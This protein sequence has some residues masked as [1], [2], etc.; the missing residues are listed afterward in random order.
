MRP[1]WLYPPSSGRHDDMLTADGDLRAH[2]LEILDSLNGLEDIP[3]RQQKA[4]RILRDDGATYNIYG[5]LNQQSTTWNLDLV[6]NVIGS[7]EWAEVESG[8]LERA[9]LF[10]LVLRDIYGERSLVRNGVIPPE[11]LFCHRGFL[12]ACHGIQLPGE[13]DLILH[14]VDLIREPSGGF[15][16][17]GD[18]TQSPSGAGYALEN[19]TVMSRVFPSLF[20]DSHV[21]RL[22]AFFQRL[23]A[24]LLSL[25]PDPAQARVALLTPGPHNETYFEHAYMA[26]YMGFPLVQSDDLMVRNGRLW[27]KSLDGLKRVDVLLRRVDDWFCDPVELRSDSRLGV[28]GLLEVVRAGN[29]VVANPLGSGIIENPVFLKYLPQIA[30][31]LLGRE[32]RLPSVNTWWCG[33]AEDKQYV[34]ANL[35]D[36]VIKPVYRKPGN[37]S[38]RACELDQNGLQQ[39]AQRIEQDPLQY[40]AQPYLKAGHLPA[41]DGSQLAP[42]PSVLRSFAVASAESYTLMPGGLTR[43]GAEE[44][45][46]VIANQAGACSKDT[47]VV[48]SEP[49]RLLSS[50][51]AE[52]PVATREAESISLPSRVVENLFWMGRYAERAESTLRI[53]RTTFMQFSSES[54]ASPVVKTHLLQALQKMAILLPDNLPAD[55][56]LERWVRDGTLSNSI[57]SNLN[58]MLFCADQAKELLSSDTFRIINDI[59]DALVKLPNELNNSLGSA[60]EEVLDPLVT[61]LMAFAGLTQESMNRSFGWRFMELGRRLERAQQINTAIRGLL[62]PVVNE[63]EQNRLAESLLLTL[64]TLISYRRRYRGR[65]SV[66]TS[67]DLILLDK[68]NP[69]SLLYQLETIAEHL[70]ALPHPATV[71]HELSDEER[72]LMQAEVLIKLTPLKELSSEEETSPSGQQNAPQEQPRQTPANAALQRDKLLSAMTRCHQLMGALNDQITDKYFDHREASQ[73]LV[74]NSMEIL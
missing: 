50:E 26:N 21:H 41:L 10:N 13:H 71:L 55:Q 60:P 62:V 31:A 22:S 7:E 37:M 45:S 24:K 65:M 19:R 18:R 43:S 74:R 32:L 49:E 33:D 40:V 73:Q 8:L 44:N 27:M 39:L 42:R 54:P 4:L 11:A 69:R 25:S 48:D 53:L 2:W 68:S 17:L 72:T 6:P 34:L 3:D 36:M 56:Q 47:W 51:H 12:R 35:K 66:Q 59:R 67:L 58:S 61:A 20:R 28:P 52:E 46:F 70:R 63:N 38:V 30:R 14:A 15:L 23:R 9:E 1:D 29:L 57:A 16:V 64:E 5:D